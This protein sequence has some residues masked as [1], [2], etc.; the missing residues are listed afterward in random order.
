MTDQEMMEEARGKIFDLCEHN[1]YGGFELVDQI[2]NLKYEDGSPMIAELAKDQ[3]VRVPDWKDGELLRGWNIA[4][5]YL[6][7]YNF[8]RIVK[9]VDNENTKS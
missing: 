6:K 3:S 2:L 1:P 5:K 8:R 4:V 7:R 9:E